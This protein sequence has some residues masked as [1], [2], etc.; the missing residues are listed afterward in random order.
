MEMENKLENSQ[1]EDDQGPFLSSKVK[2]IFKSRNKEKKQKKLKKMNLTSLLPSEEQDFNTENNINNTKNEEEDDNEN[3]Q[4]IIENNNISNEDNIKLEKKAK[5]NYKTIFNLHKNYDINFNN[6]TTDNIKNKQNSNFKFFIKEIFFLIMNIVSFIFFFQS[7]IKRTNNDIIYYYLIYPINKESFIYLIL[8]SFITSLILIFIITNVASVFHLFYSG[9]F[10]MI[11]FYKY[12][13]SNNNNIAINYFDPANCHFFVYFII[14]LHILG[15]FTIIYYVCNY[16]YL[17]GQLNKNESCLIGFLIDYW[18]SERKIAKLEKYINLNLD[19]LITSKGYSLEENIINKKKNKRVIS[20]II[21]IGFILV[22]IHIFLM[23]KKNYVF[24]CDYLDQQENNIIKPYGYCYMNKLTGYFDIYNGD[25][26]NCSK[27]NNFNKEDFINNLT[28]NY[29]NKKISQNT[30]YFA[31]PL[32]NN[33]EFYINEYNNENNILEKKINEEIFD[34]EKNSNDKIEIILN[35]ENEKNP[36]LNINLKYNEQLANE[37]KKKENK[38]SLFNNVLV[39]HLSGVSQFYFKTALPKL[40]S[41]IESYKTKDH[42]IND[43]MSMESIHFGKYHSFIDD[44][45]S[46][47]FL[48]YYDSDV[49][50][51]KDIKTKIIN[52]KNIEINDHLKYYQENGYITGQSMDTCNDE[53]YEHQLKSHNTFWDHE[54]LSPFCSS[55]FINNIKSNNYCLNEYPFYSYQIDYANQ[56]WYK[57]KDNKKYFRFNFNTTSEKTGS[58][59]SYL[60]EPLYDFFIQLKFKGLL[61]NTAIFFL[62]E[63]GGL[64]DNI[65][66][67]FGKNSE[68]EMNMKFGSFIIVIDKK[69]N[70]NESIYKS[71]H[72][73]KKVLVTP[74]DVYMSLVHI[75]MGNNIKDMKIYLDEGKRGES[76]FKKIENNDRNCEFYIEWMNKDYCYF[77]K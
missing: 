69:N 63:I 8:N 71:I 28:N 36:K 34:F 14:L 56:F 49:S 2:D 20:S 11:M 33:K 57:Y 37:R 68:K 74:F 65:F 9:L 17:N 75:T 50:A 6:K 32:T 22:F 58:L 48:M 43:K 3:N 67:N 52:N 61:E 70:L 29:N 76:I 77:H 62:S 47:K 64:Q 21:F 39:V 15:V 18:E 23:I 46:N 45:F 44:T 35:L 55:I 5:K 51:I 16:F 73:N 19:Q 31:F 60:D 41:F 53:L 59:L 25:L 12:H 1:N 72:E 24:N 4:M 10:Y 38:D 27:N 13:L 40:Y 30:K 42:D 26:N 7:F 66:Y 54:I